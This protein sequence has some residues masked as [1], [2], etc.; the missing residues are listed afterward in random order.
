[1]KQL[2]SSRQLVKKWQRRAKATIDHVDQST[3]GAAADA[4]TTRHS[5]FTASGLAIEEQLRKA[6]RPWPAGLAMF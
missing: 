4:G 1:M 3:G 5:A 6:W 2:R